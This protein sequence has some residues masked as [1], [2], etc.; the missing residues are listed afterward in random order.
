MPSASLERFC[1]SAPR[2]P[3]N[4]LMASSF[5]LPSA[6]KLI[7]AFSLRVFSYSNWY[8]LIL[9]SLIWVFAA[10]SWSA[11]SLFAEA[12]AFAERLSFFLLSASTS[13]ASLSLIAFIANS[14]CLWSASCLILICVSAAPAIS[15][16]AKASW[17]SI[18]SCC[19]LALKSFAFCSSS[20]ALTFASAT[21]WIFLICL[22]RAFISSC[23]LLIDLSWAFCWAA[24]PLPISSWSLLIIVWDLPRTPAPDFSCACIAEFKPSSNCA[25][26]IASSAVIFFRSTLTPERTI[27]HLANA[28]AVLSV[29]FK[30]ASSAGWVSFKLAICSLVNVVVAPVLELMSSIVIL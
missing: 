24:K 30:I 2:F 3:L 22:S 27:L 26:A 9:S 16:L 18:C 4:A 6:I 8:V 10:A 23:I 19:I 5:S 29:V 20:I 13:F 1:P 12:S 21:S 15:P 28:L 11:A 14:F 25:I 7:F 17:F